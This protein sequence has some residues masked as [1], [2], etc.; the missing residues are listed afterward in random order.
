MGLPLCLSASALASAGSCKVFRNEARS[1]FAVRLC[2]P[3]CWVHPAG[4]LGPH[5]R[6]SL[7]YCI[8]DLADALSPDRTLT[9]HQL[10]LLFFF[11]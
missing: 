11:F 7:S 2:R 1:C 10:V 6:P 4:V 5:H 3:S 9:F 8:I